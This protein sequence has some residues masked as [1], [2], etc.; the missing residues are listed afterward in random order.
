MLADQ[1]IQRLQFMHSKGYVH[2]DIKPE[3]LLLDGERN[4]RIV[5]FGLSTRC[6]PGQVLKHAC[7]SPCYAA[8]E[9]LTRAGQAA[10]YVGHP[11]DVWSIGVTLFAM[12]CGFLPFEHANTSVLYKKIISGAKVT[13]RHTTLAHPSEAYVRLARAGYPRSHRGAR[14]ADLSF[15]RGEGPSAQDYHD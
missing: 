12:I 10:G 3:N 1:M 9:M 13:G 2:R 5:D 11:V 7:G 15:T 14:D 6:A 4:I 8:P